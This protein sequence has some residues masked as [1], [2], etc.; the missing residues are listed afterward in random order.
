MVFFKGEKLMSRLKNNKGFSL[1]ELMIVVAIIG[2]LASV[3]I[4]NFQSFIRRSK[5]AEAKSNLSTI[6]SAQRAFHGEWQ[7]FHGHFEDL[8][9][10]PEGDLRYELTTAPGAESPVYTQRKGNA[11]AGATTTA[12]VFCGANT[13]C[14]MD[15]GAAAPVACAAASTATTFFACA[16]SDLGGANS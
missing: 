3:A 7:F 13:T 8:G 1:I 10:R 2:I 15:A 4:P 16:S 12:T 6:Y 14:Q 9:F 5:Q 11:V